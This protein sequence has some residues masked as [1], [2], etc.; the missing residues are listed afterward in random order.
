MQFS[1]IPNL[2]S[3]PLGC[4][5]LSCVSHQAERSYF[6]QSVRNRYATASKLPFAANV[7][8]VTVSES[9]EEEKTF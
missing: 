7:P 1:G 4:L 5:E 8:H 6:V 2:R 9:N 3:S